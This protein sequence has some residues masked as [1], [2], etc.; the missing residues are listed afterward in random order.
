M[1]IYPIIASLVKW[2]ATDKIYTVVLWLADYLYNKR[3]CV[4]NIKFKYAQESSP[5]NQPR[6]T[7]YNIIQMLNAT[8]NNFLRSV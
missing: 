7:H 8:R 3:T 4:N 2:A 6:T 1:I 5:M